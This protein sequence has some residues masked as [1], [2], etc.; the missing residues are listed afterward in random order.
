MTH[1]QQSGY[2][3]PFEVMFLPIKDENGEVRKLSVDIKE[4][5]VSIET[6]LDSV[7]QSIKRWKKRLEGN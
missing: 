5:T 7:Q 1:I 4:A 6:S 2:E 3:Y